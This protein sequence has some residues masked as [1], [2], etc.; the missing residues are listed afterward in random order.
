[1]APK[2]VTTTSGSGCEMIAFE[3]AIE[4]RR[5][6]T[7][8]HSQVEGI[9]MRI[10]KLE[11]TT[12]SITYAEA[13]D[14]ALCFG[15]IDGQKKS[16]DS[17]SWLQKFTPRRPRSGWSKRNTEHVD[18]LIKSKKMRGPGLKEVEAAKVDGRWSLAYESFGKAIMPD[19]FLKELSKHGAAREFFDTLSKTNRYSIFYRLQTA[20]KPETRER[21]MRQIIEMLKRGESF[22]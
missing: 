4:F 17:Q 8:N 9:W 12:L 20:K 5:W 1:M 2:G 10:Y 18:R 19:D 21:R 16:K 13:L 7:K 22:H 3:S 6:L 11:S 15:W 14:E